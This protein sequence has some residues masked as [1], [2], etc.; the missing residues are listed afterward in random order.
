MKKDKKVRYCN[1]AF[2]QIIGYSPEHLT[3]EYVENIVLEEFDLGEI[4]SG[5]SMPF[6]AS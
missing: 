4:S 1:D 2:V 5:S 6:K 3:P